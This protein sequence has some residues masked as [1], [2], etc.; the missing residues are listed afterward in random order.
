MFFRLASPYK[1][2]GWPRALRRLDQVPRP[3]AHNADHQEK[4]LRR[5][6]LINLKGICV[7]KHA[8]GLDAGWNIDLPMVVE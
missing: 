6:F 3:G 7:V 2:D 5:H 8:D 1:A 4:A